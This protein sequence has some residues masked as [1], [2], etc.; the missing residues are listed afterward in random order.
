ML[1][2]MNK[3]SEFVD[4]VFEC[5]EQD[6]PFGNLSDKFLLSLYLTY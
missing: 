3:L 6:I 4:E 2:F 1:Q 5:I